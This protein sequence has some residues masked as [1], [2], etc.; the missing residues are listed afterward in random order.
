MIEYLSYGV[1]RWFA[2][3]GVLLFFII[4]RMSKR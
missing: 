3:L 1:P 4:G 2:A